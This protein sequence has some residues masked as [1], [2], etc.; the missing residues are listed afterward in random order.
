MSLSK[1]TMSLVQGTL[2]TL[3]MHKG[4]PFYVSVLESPQLCL[5]SGL[6]ILLAV[7]C[8][9]ETS[10]VFNRMLELRPWVAQRHKVFVLGLAILDSFVC[11]VIEWYCR[12]WVNG[13][14]SARNGNKRNKLNPRRLTAKVAA[15]LEEEALQE[16]SRKN[17]RLVFVFIGGVV[18]MALDAILKAAFGVANSPV[19]LQK[20]LIVKG[21]DTKHIMP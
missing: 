2:T 19:Q 16:E 5:W 11:S 9:L 20:Q 8:M 3:L 1:V 4:A 14:N 18:A 15:D 13:G 12:W 7:A 21:A 10:P 6:S 17:G